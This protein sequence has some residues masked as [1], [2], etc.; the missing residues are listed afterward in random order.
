MERQPLVS[1]ARFRRRLLIVAGAVAAVSA[2]AVAIV[3]HRGA[4]TERD[5]LAQPLDVSPTAAS[6]LAL[7]R[8]R[9]DLDTEEA[10]LLAGIAEQPTARWI[11]TPERLVEET[12]QEAVDGAE[13]RDAVATL[14]AYNIPG[15]D[16]GGHS[17]SGEQV[18]GEDYRAWIDAFVEG[19]GDHRAIVVLE[20]DALAQLDCLSGADADERLGLLHEAVLELSAQG[21]RVY[22][23]A[24]HSAWMPAATAAERLE[25]AGVGDA[26]GFS[27]NVSNFRGTDDQIDY[28]RE[29]S[30]EIDGATPFVIDTSRNGRGT[31]GREWCNPEGVG[32]GEPPT[33]DTGEE[34]V[35][36]FLWIKMPGNSDGEC[37]GGP[38]AGQWWTEYALMLARNAV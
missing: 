31:E 24:G 21:S 11:A 3:L 13:Q 14:V 5:P 19:L 32:L 37:N 20:P 36:A 28:G 16:C 23:D 9:A 15:R 35:D 26:A 1:T 33:T 4:V 8:E 29:V 27:L 2:V 6:A 38:P 25:A 12:V 17:A 30:D 7:D 18:A 34:R 22:L 10:A